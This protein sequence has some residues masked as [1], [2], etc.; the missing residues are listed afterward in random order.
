MTTQRLK[1]PMVLMLLA[2]LALI[3]PATATAQQGPRHQDGGHGHFTNPGHILRAADELELSDDQRGEIRTLMEQN[4]ATIKP[5]R[6]QLQEEGKRLKEMMADSALERGEV[7]AQLDR[8]LALEGQ[9]KRQRAE[10]FLDIRDV[11]TAD[12]RAQAQ[13]LFEERGQQMRNRRGEHRGNRGEQRQQRR[14]RSR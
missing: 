10:A 8:V 12:Q 9:V 4:R 11:L 7:L 2:A 6:E 1:F 3:L 13:E 14:Q 5:V